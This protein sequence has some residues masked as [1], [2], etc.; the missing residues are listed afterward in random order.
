[1]V[2]YG[3]ESLLLQN[4]NIFKSYKLHASIEEILHNISVTT[5]ICLNFQGRQS[6]TK[7]PKINLAKSFI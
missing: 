5:M 2:Y 3:E 7:D 4:E 6:Y 1:M